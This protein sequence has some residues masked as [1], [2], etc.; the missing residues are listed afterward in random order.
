[1]ADEKCPRCQGKD[2][3]ELFAGEVTAIRNHLQKRK[4]ALW[5]WGDRL[6]DGKTTGLGE[7]EA[8]LNDT[9]RAIDLVPKDIV[10]CDW[11]YERPDLT[12]VYFAMKGLQV[13]TCPWKNE[14]SAT[15]QVRD[16]V[17]F[18]AQ[19]TPQVRD[20]LLG[21]MQTVWSGAESF[22]DSYSRVKSA[23]TNRTDQPSDAQCFIRVLDEISALKNTPG[24]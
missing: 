18:R 2:K 19:S 1:L 20:R 16:V 23:G 24:Q 11:H 13:V 9:H 8:S 5:I 4:A 17:R 22:L 10:I 6:L 12:A 21:I 14:K 7:W 15:Q 3:A